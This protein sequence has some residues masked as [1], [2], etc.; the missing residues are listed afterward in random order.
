MVPVEAALL[1]L[2]RTLFVFGTT[3][4]SNAGRSEVGNTDNK[5]GNCGSTTEA[6]C[7]PKILPLGC[8]K[9]CDAA[10]SGAVVA[11][12][13][14]GNEGGEYKCRDDNS[15]ETNESGSL[16][17]TTPVLFLPSLTDDMYDGFLDVALV[18]DFNNPFSWRARCR[19]AFSCTALLD[20]GL[21]SD[22]NG[23]NTLYLCIYTLIESDRQVWKREVPDF[24]RGSSKIPSTFEQLSG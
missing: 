2:F 6:T 22:V 18:L 4:A 14:A 9:C 20:I 5:F 15:M 13:I 11:V 3:A 7:R 12:T 1:P 10:I 17:M 19:C 24:F 23:N 8:N 16:F 21:S